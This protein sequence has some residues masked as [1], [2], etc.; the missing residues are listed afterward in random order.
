M[1]HIKQLYTNGCS[2]TNDTNLKNNGGTC[3]PEILAERLGVELVNSGH[4][5]SCNRRV[6]RT[7]LRD[8]INFDSSTLVVV[9]LPYLF[10]YEKPYV[11]E[12]VNRWKVNAPWQ[13]GE[14]MESVKPADGSQS[15]AAQ[16]YTQ[17][18]VKH[19]EYPA[20]FNE[21][22]IDVIMLTGYLRSKNIPY[23]IY[24]HYCE[25]DLEVVNNSF[26]QTVLNDPYVFNI[27]SSFVADI[28]EEKY[29]YDSLY[30][31]LNQAGHEL[32][33]DKLINTLNKCY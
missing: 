12:T 29:Y 28:N 8:S 26:Y 5:G 9:Q 3:W 17:C 18:M 14:I 27:D 4:P 10:R 24:R 1:K 7:T 32:L 30:A 13:H 33:A 22:L 23:L 20:L 2:F 11:D 19:W 25:E 31:H 21:N 6:I 15:P 16:E